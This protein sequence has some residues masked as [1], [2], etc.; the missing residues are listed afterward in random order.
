MHHCADTKRNHEYSA[1]ETDVPSGPKG[2]DQNE[3]DAERGETVGGK[4]HLA[5]DS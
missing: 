4:N 5:A 1:I 3:Q 2:T